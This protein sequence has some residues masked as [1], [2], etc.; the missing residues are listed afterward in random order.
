MIAQIVVLVSIVLGIAVMVSA[1]E[2]ARVHYEPTWESLDQHPTPEW[3][4]DAK[5]GLF[6]YLPGP[7]QAV[8]EAYWASRG[9]P[10]KP[11]PA[12]NEQ[13]EDSLEKVNWDPAALAQLAV[14]MGAR[15][16]VFG[17]RWINFLLWPSDY[18]DIEGSPW[19]SIDGPGKAQRDYVQ[20]MVGAA[21]QRGLKIGFYQGYYHPRKHPYFL[22][23]MYEV[24]DAYQPDT[25]WFD[26]HKL[27]YPATELKSRELLAYYYNHSEKQDEVAAEDALGSHKRATWGRELAHGDWFR[28]EMSPPHS[29][30]PEGH[31]VR[32]ETAYR[33]R[34]RSPVG[35]PEGLVKNLIEWLADAT[36]KNGNLEI[37]IHLREPLFQLER[38]T[39]LQVGMWLRVNGE[40][41]YE[42]RPWHDG[43][44]EDRTAEG[45]HV[46]YTVK[47]DSLYA[48]LFRWPGGPNA[49][50]VFPHLRAQEGSRAEM[51]G[52]ER[53]L[54]WQQ[55]DKGL[56]VHTPSASGASGFETEIPCDHAYVCKIT[57]RPTWV[58]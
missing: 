11:P 18:A 44:P 49:K 52:I 34:N 1:D 36:S 53:D 9:Q 6:I 56:E 33:W 5:L 14:D 38:D 23:T 16:V 21:R 13:W 43:R 39:L 40:A 27:S 4:M 31:F 24:I 51:L 29:D 17:A 7:N 3:F 45:I 46:R 41:I 12:G 50:F 8:Y 42:A 25:L 30:I 22:E 20:E 35:K 28:K 19:T 32:Y 2:P 54:S 10:G 48:I 57:P 55:T 58:D 15:Y 37:A 26:N 47:G